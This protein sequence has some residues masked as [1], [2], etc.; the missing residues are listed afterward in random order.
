MI[1]NKLFKQC[2][3]AIDQQMEEAQ[4]KG[5]SRYKAAREVSKWVKE[6][7]QVNI[8]SRTIE[9][10][11]RRAEKPVTN[12][13]KPKPEPKPQ[14]KEKLGQRPEDNL[15]MIMELWEKITAREQEDFH[16]WAAFKCWGSPQER[17]TLQIRELQRQLTYLCENS[18]TCPNFICKALPNR[19][20]LPLYDQTDLKGAQKADGPS[21]R[22]LEK[23]RT[24]IL[25]LEKETEGLLD[26]ILGHGGSH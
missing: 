22:T 9:M 26:V 1:I 11:A 7:L 23:V 20:H 18:N 21:A 25:V 10:R 3:L 8:K 14:P 13:T 19:N 2:E 15:T 17:M 6:K 4:A 5:I 24:D 12:V 16:N